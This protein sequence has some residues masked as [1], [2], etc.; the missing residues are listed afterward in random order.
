[1]LEFQYWTPVMLAV[2]WGAGRGCGFGS[3]MDPGSP[4]FT[5]AAPEHVAKT[6]LPC[7]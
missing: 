7:C 3:G 1:V 2:Y 5:T 4:W 6:V